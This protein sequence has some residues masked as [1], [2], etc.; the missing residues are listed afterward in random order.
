M[1]ILFHNVPDEVFGFIISQMDLPLS[2]FFHGNTYNAKLEAHRNS[3][4]IGVWCHD[5]RNRTDSYPALCFAM[6]LLDLVELCC[7]YNH[8]FEEGEKL[9]SRIKKNQENGETILDYQF[10]KTICI[11]LKTEFR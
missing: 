11:K 7:D 5:F 1:T 6:N 3:Q 10:L 2:H 9:L 8:T 4:S